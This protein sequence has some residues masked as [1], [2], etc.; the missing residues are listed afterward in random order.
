[1]FQI[2]GYNGIGLG[3]GK[4]TINP[5]GKST[6]VIQ[7]FIKNGSSNSPLEN[8]QL[9]AFLSLADTSTVTSGNGFY[10]ITVLYTGT[11]TL[12]FKSYSYKTDYVSLSVFGNSVWNNMSFT[13]AHK[14]AI[15]GETLGFNS[16][17]SEPDV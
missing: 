14:F 1:M 12:A 3:N 8:T 4:T 11:Y 16:L 9:Y 7:G 6:V 2:Q 15:E 10:K 5:Q 17:V 13:P